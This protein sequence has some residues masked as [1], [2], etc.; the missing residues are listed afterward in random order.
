MDTFPISRVRNTIIVEKSRRI[1][2]TYIV[3]SENYTL[4]KE[5]DMPGI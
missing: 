4:A 1:M 3:I 5:N 2:V